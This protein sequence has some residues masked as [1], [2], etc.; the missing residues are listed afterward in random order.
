MLNSIKNREVFNTLVEWG[1][2]HLLTPEFSTHLEALEEEFKDITEEIDVKGLLLDM[3]NEL[4]SEI[5]NAIEILSNPELITAVEED[6]IYLDAEES[7]VTLDIFTYFMEAVFYMVIKNDAQEYNKIFNKIDDITSKIL[8]WLDE[9]N[10]SPLR[11]TI[12][13]ELRRATLYQI[14]ED[15]RYLFPWYERLSELPEY[16]LMIIIENYDNIILG[17]NRSVPEEL[18]PYYNEIVY[19]LRKDKELNM[20]LKEESIIHTA[21]KEV[22]IERS[23]TALWA[24]ADESAY[25]YLIPET[26]LNKGVVNVSKRLIEGIVPPFAIRKEVKAYYL[27]MAAFCGP[28]LT[29][30]QRLE[31]FDK[32]EDIIKKLEPNLEGL[33]D[34]Q[35][36]ILNLLRRWYEGDDTATPSLGKNA[37]ETW[38][39]L[40]IEIAEEMEETGYDASP[41]E[42]W[43]VLSRL[44]EM[45]E[46]PSVLV[47]IMNKIRQWA[48]RGVLN[49]EPTLSGTYL[50]MDE[51]RDITIDTNPLRISIPRSSER[52]Y[53]LLPEPEDVTSSTQEEY[54]RLWNG[55]DPRVRTGIYTGGL[56]LRHDRLEKIPVQELQDRKFYT[57]EGDFLQIFLGISDDRNQLDAFVGKLSEDAGDIERDAF[58]VVVLEISIENSKT[59]G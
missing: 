33:D 30:A 51:E 53:Q 6:S 14:P 26:V 32:V 22:A 47:R 20:V 15:K 13:N 10:Y 43:Q 40:L 34:T 12:F 59:D 41:E 36:T 18:K 58:N 19:E 11:L 28:S 44:S 2:T 25:E 54:E 31:L 55:L 7:F 1:K 16:T 45:R 24:L 38:Q 37:F 35:T 46:I 4:E 29:N 5:D 27:F 21:L 42:F 49:P 52:K 56:I 48:N 39:N 9:S 23:S 8:T 17:D 57:V 3:L 50:L